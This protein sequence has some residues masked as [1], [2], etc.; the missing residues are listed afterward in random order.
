MS[1]TLQDIINSDNTQTKNTNLADNNHAVEKKISTEESVLLKKIKETVER[2]NSSD[3]DKKII[4]IEDSG[5]LKK[6]KET[7]EKMNSS[8]ADKKIITEDSELL[9]K[10]KE[11]IEEINSSE[12][13]LAGIREIINKFSTTNQFDLHAIQGVEKNVKEQNMN[14]EIGAFSLTRV[15]EKAREALLAQT[16]TD[17]DNAVGI[18]GYLDEQEADNK[19]I[20]MQT[21]LEESEA[22][23][24]NTPNTAEPNANISLDIEA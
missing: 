11:M 4:V 23:K 10:I 3:V 9:K 7:I 8:D 20:A 24:Y 12:W 18:L 1:K 2:M 6:I 13:S 17:S 19:K 14:L 15:M 16:N 21:T 5:L 22:N